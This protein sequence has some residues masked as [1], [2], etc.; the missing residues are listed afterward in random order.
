[1]RDLTS[2]N[3]LALFRLNKIENQWRTE[4]G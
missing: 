1:M 2:I 3:R 4:Q